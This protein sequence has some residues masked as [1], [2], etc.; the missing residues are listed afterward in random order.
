[1]SSPTIDVG[2]HSLKAKIIRFASVNSF[3]GTGL[4]VILLIWLDAPKTATI[5]GC[6]TA[7][8]AVAYFLA[9]GGHLKLAS[10]VWMIVGALVLFFASYQVHPTGQIILIEV[11][12]AVTAFL[13]FGSRKDRGS[14]L[15]NLGFIVTLW[16]IGTFYQADI[17]GPRE[18]GMEAAVTYAVPLT[19]ATIMPS[20]IAV[21]YFF[22]LQVQR[23]NRE[24]ADS[25]ERAQHANDAKSNFLAT[26]SHEIRTPMNGVV[27]IVELLE[28]TKLDDEQ[29]R[30]LGIAKQS[31]FALLD[32]IGDILDNSKIEAGKIVIRR[33]PV[34]SLSLLSRVELL[35]GPLASQVG[36][37]LKAHAEGDV[38]AAFWGD[39]VRV[40]QVLMN[41]TGNA[42]KFSNPG[43]GTSA[44]DVLLDMRLSGDNEIC[45]EIR[46]QGIGMTDEQVELLFSPF[47]QFEQAETRR[48]GGTG[49][50]LSI[51]AG[52]AKLMNGRIEVES[53]IGKGSVF[54]FYLPL[55]P[56]TDIQLAKADTPQEV[57]NP[58][59][60]GSGKILVA[61]DNPVNQLVL[62]KQIE[63]LG[64]EA[65]MADDG[66][67]AFLKWSSGKY[68]LLLTDCQ[69]PN[70]DGYG[71]TEAIRRTEG[72]KGMDRL[73]IIAVTANALDG[74]DDRCFAAGM[75]GYISKPFSMD[76]LKNLLEKYV[77]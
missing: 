6:A 61:E 36:L 77:S 25:A 45:F 12:M 21:L 44:K 47:T 10:N 63:S 3:I 51:S 52:L 50:G 13:F 70:L 62:Q 75:D 54:R 69:M 43:L 20:I 26:M 4:W 18:I 15:L 7:S 64:Y 27:G 55:E 22:T 49:L 28:N 60:G 23:K 76:E 35:L 31:S 9:R 57:A 56:V 53:A 8:S 37:T 73:P 32:I 68:D 2:V 74:A 72:E 59:Q 14:L 66:S 38:P 24:L 71:L 48:F 65:E 40:G 39:S 42:I 41:L 30:L 1:M 17:L 46:D 29:R 33:E 34:N 16:A 19:G 58:T 5:A 67:D 11:M